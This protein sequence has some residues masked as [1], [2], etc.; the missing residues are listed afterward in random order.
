MSL[1]ALSTPIV[2]KSISEKKRPPPIKL[3]IRTRS[4]SS[5]TELPVQSPYPKYD[6]DPSEIMEID[7]VKI[8]LGT[9]EDS[10]DLK[11]IEKENIGSIVCAMKEKPFLLDIKE[12]I[13]FLHIP[14]DDLCS[15]RISEYFE[16]FNN[17]VDEN[18]KNKRNIFVHCHM[19]ISR[20]PS[21]IISY[22]ITKRKMNFREAYQFVKSK[23][24]QIEPNMGFQLLLESISL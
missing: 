11:F 6:F 9:Y 13:N 21:F 19:G 17:F 16:T 4:N 12:E 15:E 14:V 8:F 18:I 2:M 5:N 1:K 3:K 7:G 22:L 20:S 23:R 24:G 10:R